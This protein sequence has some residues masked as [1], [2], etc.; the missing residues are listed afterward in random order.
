LTGRTTRPAP[1]IAPLA[2][3]VLCGVTLLL[4][5]A[6][7]AHAAKPATGATVSA[8]Q[9][10]AF[11]DGVARAWESYTTVEGRVED[12]LNPH[13][14]GDN[15]GVIMLADV[16][17]KVARQTADR[18]I[19]SAGERIID[20]VLARPVPKDLF[21]LLAL[22]ALIRDGREGRFPVGAWE[23]LAG[24]LA[25]MAGQIGPPVGTSCLTRPRCYSNW[26]LV[27]AAGAAL[28]A[29]DEL[30]GE[31]DSLAGES[32]FVKAQIESNLDMAVT[33]AGDPLRASLAGRARPTPPHSRGT[34]GAHRVAGSR[35]RRGGS[36]A[37]SRSGLGGLARELSDPGGEPPAYELFSTFMLE[38]VCESDPSAVTPAVA[39]LRAQA[40]RYALAMMAPDG[41]LSLTGRSLD[42]SWVQA[43]AAALGARRAELDPA[44]A[45]QWG[46]F[47]SRAVSYLLS[48]Y[49]L[50]RDGLIPV[51]PG[52]DL[53]WSPSIMDGY[54]ALSEYEG[55]TL[56][57][58]SDALEHWPPEPAPRAPLP[59]DRRSLLV[60]DLASSGLVWGQAHG[61]WWELSGRST[62]DDP[63]DA[64]GLVA[65]KV[66]RTAH[67]HD[68]LAL[69]PIQSK[70]SSAWVLGL[71]H[72]ATATPSFGQVQGT[73]ASAALSGI[74]RRADGR[75]AARAQWTLRT[76]AT[77][78]RLSMTVPAKATLH[79]TVWLAGAVRVWSPDA[80]QTA[81][82]CVV[83]ASGRACPVTI[84]WRGVRVATLMLGRR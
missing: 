52:L 1:L 55:L 10:G 78:V 38:L 65:V 29:A 80:H 4:L 16:M 77:G 23:R 45:G 13:D 60:D 6:P 63:R 51:V 12:P 68:L 72:S 39:R 64:Q 62:N 30:P 35:H 41:Q 2:L 37:L 67:W 82:R 69:R 17:L 24:P 15:Y 31:P 66:G 76:T 3:G 9:L 75:V 48:S 28:L 81:G 70:R 21:N 50:T 27:W 5:C 71:E 7:R 11:L 36:G 25:L 8:Q 47:A 42:Q 84:S 26:R 33:H 83:S 20:S 53:R 61:I 54:V 14:A 46:A 22:A 59:A 58:L 40:D 34:R 79:T 56:W 44:N 19:E 18:G 74:Y 43:A 73:G 32:A 57:L 49:P